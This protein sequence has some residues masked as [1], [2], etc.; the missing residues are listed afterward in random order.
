[1]TTD[2]TFFQQI[3]HLS[4]NVVVQ[5]L[6]FILVVGIALA[7]TSNIISRFLGAYINQIL[8]YMHGSLWLLLLA[9]FLYMV[10][11]AVIFIIPVTPADV[12]MFAIVGPKLVFVF[13][14][15]GTLVAYVISYFLARRFGRRFLK[16][17][18]PKK[19]YNRVDAMSVKMNWQQFFLISAIP[20]NQPDIMPYVAGLTK[21]KFRTA[22]G[23]LALIVALRLFFVLFVLQQFWVGH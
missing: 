11:Q 23:I 17:I 2:R 19:A 16:R 4:G 10:V 7:L 15:T 14:L 9:Y 3:K 12:A 5:S 21:V 8:P 1:M 20:F 22:I 13:N 6:L 18:L